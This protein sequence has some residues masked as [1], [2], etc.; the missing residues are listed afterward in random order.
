MLV[1]FGV[2]QSLDDSY[3]AE[4]LATGLQD[5]LICIEMML[6]S[7]AHLYTFSY[8]PFVEGGSESEYVA[9]SDDE[10]INSGRATTLNKTSHGTGTSTNS[11][12][13]DYR[14][15]R[16]GEY[17]RVGST[18]DDDGEDGT[19]E[20]INSSNGHS[21]GMPREEPMKLFS[22]RGQSGYRPPSQLA[23]SSS[24]ASSTVY[25]ALHGQPLEMEP[26]DA[27]THASASYDI[28]DSLRAPV[29]RGSTL[30]PTLPITASSNNGS[31]SSSSS[32]MNSA[33][34]RNAPS[35]FDLEQDVTGHRK[36]SVG[37]TAVSGA[38]AASRSVTEVL[39]RHFAS[40]SAVR[41]FNEAMPVVVLPSNFKPA[42]GVVIDS[43]P[44]E[45]LRRYRE[46][47]DN[48]P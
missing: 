7:I 37:A 5:F 36:R 44:N 14:R 28:T 45:R 23:P 12:T 39:N 3:S 47:A 35:Q 48:S 22:I 30:R 24:T 21:S 27:T 18:E 10:S 31:A 26:S 46:D 11:S 40:S 33:N 29:L 16:L 9:V 15:R 13:G 32:A 20:R 34:H 1:M 19:R 2:I 17:A 6:V 4:T 8:K 41:D 43:D 25:N 38:K 42:K